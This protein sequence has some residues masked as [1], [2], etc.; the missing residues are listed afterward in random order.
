LA[1]KKRAAVPDGFSKC[2]D[3]KKSLTG[4]KKK[5]SGE[6]LKFSSLKGGNEKRL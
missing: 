5:S 1:K 6:E 2:K 4:G 3:A